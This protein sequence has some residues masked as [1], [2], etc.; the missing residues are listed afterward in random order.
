MISLGLRPRYRVRCENVAQFVE[1]PY[2]W[3]VWVAE[4]PDFWA[5]AAT[6]EAVP[7]AVR[8]EVAALLHVT[9][10]RFDVELD[11]DD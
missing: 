9:P 3:F 11:G 5:T 2:G 6:K 10:D 1:D 7:D 4:L 8:A